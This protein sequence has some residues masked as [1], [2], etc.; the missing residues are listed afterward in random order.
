M[1]IQPRVRRRFIRIL[2]AFGIAATL[3]GCIVVPD[4]GGYYRPHPYRPYY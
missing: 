2:A 4:G 1:S 3:G